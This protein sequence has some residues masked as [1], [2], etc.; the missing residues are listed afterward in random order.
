MLFPGHGRLPAGRQKNNLLVTLDF[1]RSNISLKLN[2]DRHLFS[3]LILG[4]FQ[5]VLLN[6]LELANIGRGENGTYLAAFGNDYIFYRAVAT[7]LWNILCHMY[8]QTVSG[9]LAG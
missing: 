5:L 1:Y 4:H 3:F 6:N 8:K 2:V 7:I 9:R